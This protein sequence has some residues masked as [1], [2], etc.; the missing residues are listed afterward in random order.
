VGNRGHR[1]ELITLFAVVVVTAVLLGVIA[2]VGHDDDT[3]DSVAE[4]A[5]SSVTP[6]PAATPESPAESAEPDPGV[7]DHALVYACRLVPRGDVERI[8]GSLWPDARTRQTYLD[9]RPATGES[10]A[11]AARVPGGLTTS[12]V[13]SFGD[14][15]GHSLEVD[16]T[17]LATT[18][19]VEQRWSDL[20]DDGRVVSGTD[21]RMLVQPRQRSFALRGDDFVAELRYT[22]VGDAARTRPLSEHELGWQLPRMRQVLDVAS[23]AVA[24]GSASIGPQLTNENLGSSVAGTAYLAPCALLTETAF[25]ALGGAAPGPTVV[26]SSYV[27]HDPYADV[28][29][30]SCERRGTEPNGRPRDAETTYAVLEIRIA[31]DAAAAQ[32]VEAKHLDNRYPRGQQV[33]QVSTQAGPA[34][35]VDVGGT[36]KSPWRTR[37][38]H[39]VVG[40]YELQLSVLR[41]VSPRQPSGHWVGRAQLVAAADE[42]IAAMA[43]G[44]VP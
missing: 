29:M 11:P 21:D 36:K 8:F 19:A 2:M 14:P 42:V 7:G 35:V 37:A 31:S 27:P 28:P 30:G 4:P 15:A 32:E 23:R 12:C 16:V 39:V 3:P 38:L 22:T 34:Y 25:A 10:V 6:T 44:V 18:S 41:D 43:S 13:Y 9:R 40:S 33:D 20:T 5:P 24:D 17:Q 1:D 26:D